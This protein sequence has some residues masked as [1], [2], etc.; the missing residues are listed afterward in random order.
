VATLESF[1]LEGT[2]NR[3]R[4]GPLPAAL[5][6]MGALPQALDGIIGLSFLSQFDSVEFN[7][8]DELVS[9]Y[10]NDTP[11]PPGHWNKVA[12][13][14]M[15]MLGSLGIYAVDTW[16][17]GRGP[18]RML[19]DTGAATSYWS[20]SGVSKNLHI[21]RDS[22][23]VQRLSNSMGV[24]GSDNKATPL[25]HRI[26]V[27][28]RMGL[29]GGSGVDLSNGRIAVDIG[30]IPILQHLETLGVGGMLGLDLMRRCSAVLV[31]FKGVK[32]YLQLYAAAPAS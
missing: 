17:G 11:A 32:P 6:D 24:M 1:G 10:D 19:V 12:E 4:F 28:S 9:L 8:V 29:P 26:Y 13:G 23:T 18:I 5:Q 31:R 7:F 3:R 27:S 21:P 15:H 30:D 14:E 22:P 2:S 20:W 25:T 16:W